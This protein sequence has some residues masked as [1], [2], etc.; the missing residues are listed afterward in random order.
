M[1]VGECLMITS[2]LIFYS[3][4]YIYT[5]YIRNIYK[6]YTKYTYK[7]LGEVYNVFVYVA[8]KPSP[9]WTNDF[10]LS[11]FFCNVKLVWLSKRLSKCVFHRGSPILSWH[12]LCCGNAGALYLNVVKLDIW[13]FRTL[14]TV[15]TLMEIGF[16]I[17]IVKIRF[18]FIGTYSGRNWSGQGHYYSYRAPLKK[19]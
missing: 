9:F 3:K 8:T 10:I 19:N 2:D 5:Q 11:P 18:E 7:I 15:Y 6:I 14:S 16:N 17:L 4:K 13:I 1:C 12:L